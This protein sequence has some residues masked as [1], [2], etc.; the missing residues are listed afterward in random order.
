MIDGRF[1][2]FVVA[3]KVNWLTTR[4]SPPTSCTERFIKPCS[5]LKMRR[6]TSLPA[7]HSMSS[8]G[9]FKVQGPRSKVATSRAADLGLWTLNNPPPQTRPTRANRDRYSPSP[10]HRSSHSRSR[11]VERPLSFLRLHRLRPGHLVFRSEEHTP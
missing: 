3:N 2:F 10:H 5:S 9:W 8:V 6:R 1:P 11:L 7:S 4:I